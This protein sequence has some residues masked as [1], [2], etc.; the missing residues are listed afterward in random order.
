MKDFIEKNGAY[1]M[2]EATIKSFNFWNQQPVPKLTQVISN[3][4]YIKELYLNQFNSNNLDKKFMI[5]ILDICN[6]K[7]IQAVYEFLNINYI[8]NIDTKFKLHHSVEYLKWLFNIPNNN[9]ELFIV[10]KSK[11]NNQLIG[12]IFGFIE[13]MQVNKNKLYIINSKLL[14]VHQKYRNSGMANILITELAKKGCQLGY[15]VGQFTTGR[16]IPSPFCN[17]NINYRPINVKKI[18]STNFM[19]IQDTSLHTDNKNEMQEIIKYYSIPDH[20]DTHNFILMEDKHL[21]VACELLNNYLEKFNYYRIFTQQEFNYI[22]HNNNIISS[23]VLCNDEGECID[24][25]SIYKQK[26]K[27]ISS[28]DYINSVY[29]YYYTSHS[30]T[31]YQLVKYLLVLVKQQKFDIIGMYNVMEN[32]DVV[33]ELLFTKASSINHYFY[34]WNCKKLVSSQIGYIG[35]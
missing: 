22:F 4:G 31:I 35:A 25:I 20:L 12:C 14:C 5:D 13:H 28:N 33:N 27:I 1:T 26:S 29:V 9:K 34:N 15:S 23:Y 32:D 6:A 10:I 19:S 8:N 2:E 18:L 16:I 3:D 11:S 24:F 17:I 21:I 7:Q 30:E